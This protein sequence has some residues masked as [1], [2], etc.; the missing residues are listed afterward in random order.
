MGLC[1]SHHIN[2]FAANDIIA[3][4]QIFRLGQPSSTELPAQGSERRLVDNIHI[5]RHKT[6]QRE[7]AADVLPKKDAGHLLLF[8]LVNGDH[9][10]HDSHRFQSCPLH[11]MAICRTKSDCKTVQVNAI[12]RNSAQTTLK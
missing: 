12:C 9:S 8:V 4:R 3:A 2:A 7:Y 5:P 11:V 10:L 1:P 6:R